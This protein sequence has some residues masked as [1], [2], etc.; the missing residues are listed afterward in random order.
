MSIFYADWQSTQAVFYGSIREHTVAYGTQK[1]N[2]SEEGLGSTGGDT[3]YEAG[4]LRYHHSSRD[5][6]F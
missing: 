1:Q 4:K 3:V 5:R 2:P 6:L